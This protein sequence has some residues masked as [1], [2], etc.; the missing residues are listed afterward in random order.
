MQKGLGQWGPP[1]RGRQGVKKG[2]VAQ[3][4]HPH[5]VPLAAK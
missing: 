3:K 5:S 2:G 1:G 4:Q